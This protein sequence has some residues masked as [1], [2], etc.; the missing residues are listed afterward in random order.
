M[1]GTTASGQASG[2]Y[3]PHFGDSTGNP[4]AWNVTRSNA[5]AASR[6]TNAAFSRFGLTPP[7]ARS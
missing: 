1:V 3:A 7:V 6:P 2:H 4:T 5:S